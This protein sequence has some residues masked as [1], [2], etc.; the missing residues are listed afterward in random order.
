MKDNC[1]TSQQGKK[2]EIKTMQEKKKT[3]GRGTLD[4]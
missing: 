4:L 3:A 2:V 1:K